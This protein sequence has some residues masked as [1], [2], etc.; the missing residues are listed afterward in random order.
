MG[1]EQYLFDT[2]MENISPI[3]EEYTYK[4]LDKVK[5]FKVPAVALQIMTNN[6]ICDGCYATKGD[7]TSYLNISVYPLNNQLYM[8]VRKEII[9]VGSIDVRRLKHLF[10]NDL[11]NCVDSYFTDMLP[12]SLKITS[13]H[14][15]DY[16]GYAFRVTNP[17]IIKFLLSYEKTPKHVLEILRNINNE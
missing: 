10:L 2:N 5:S 1:T 16:T 7:T 12:E 6:I 4:V 9:P 3:S 8:M 13:D 17:K 15:G 14:L 11:P